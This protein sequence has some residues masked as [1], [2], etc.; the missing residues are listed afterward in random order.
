MA[1]ESAA[2][3]EVAWGT[4]APTGSE[5]CRTL[6]TTGQAVQRR[7]DT[8]VAAYDAGVAAPG[9]PTAE[10][11]V[12]LGYSTG[13]V[14]KLNADG[15][16]VFD[17]GVGWADN[18]RSVPGIDRRSFEAWKRAYWRARSCDFGGC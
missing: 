9:G 4:A 6:G 2:V 1:E 18:A 5:G 14:T 7:V 12:A 15:W 3:G 10:R 8:V 17:A 16:A 11:R 13:A